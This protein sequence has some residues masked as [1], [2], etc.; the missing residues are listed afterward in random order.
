M[1]SKSGPH[2]TDPIRTAVI[3]LGNIGLGYDLDSKRDTIFTHTKACLRHNA[4]ELVAGVDPD[5]QKRAAFTKIT[6]K[7]TYANI[8][9][10][11]VRI[12]LIIIATP[13]P[14]HGEAV[15]KSIQ[16]SPKAILIEKPI[17]N[18]IHEA[19]KIINICNTH[20]IALYIN[21]FRNFDPNIIAI[22]NFI[23]ENN[24]GPFRH[25]ICNYSR[26][27]L[28]NASHMI[29]LL[30]TF[31]GKPHTIKKIGGHHPF[32][33]HDINASFM[34]G[35][36][37][38]TAY[39]FPLDE[40]Y[41]LVEMDIFLQAGRLRLENYCEDITAFSMRQDPYYAGYNRLIPAE[42]QPK[43]PDFLRYQY[44]VM[45]RLA[46]DMQNEMYEYANGDNAMTTLDICQAII[47]ETTDAD[48]LQ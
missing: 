14:Y 40:R 28:N 10:I 22:N 37:G 26:G 36:N 15:E 17:A 46:K 12:D 1:L 5:K 45:D 44:H 30:L 9:D 43:Q 24:Y 25:I 6:N 27:I 11:K 7:D 2:N 21:Y 19:E 38:V 42:R 41:D 47:H 48:S 31:L 4:F 16:L 23:V 32:G 29:S 20:N 39:F 18:N 35:F 8:N 34:L 33:A 13:T 3:G